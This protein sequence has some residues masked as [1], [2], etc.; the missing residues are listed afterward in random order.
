M[1][2][3]SLGANS[4]EVVFVPNPTT[5]FNTVLRN[6]DFKDGDVVLHFNT[7]YGACLKTIQS[8]GETSPVVPYQ[9]DIAFPIEDDEII[10][11]FQA[12]VQEI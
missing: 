12:A 7:T 9:I 4:D 6:L 3:I 8:L 5:G 1:F 11:R 10:R 2:F